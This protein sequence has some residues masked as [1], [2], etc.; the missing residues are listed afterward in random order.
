MTDRPFY[1]A[2]RDHTRT[3]GKRV[4]S[5][6]ALG[7]HCLRIFE[8]A[9]SESSSRTRSEREDISR[10]HHRRRSTWSR[11]YLAL[12]R[13]RRQNA[14]LERD[15]LVERAIGLEEQ[16]EASRALSEKLLKERDQAAAR[17]QAMES[18]KFWKLRRKWFLLRQFV[19][20]PG[21]E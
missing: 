15:Q 7:L 1:A 6:E 4:W 8:N 20:L 11:S 14:E 12:E 18:T 10:C 2:A 9:V 5:S 19:G 3:A 17:I 21:P 16:V 13:A